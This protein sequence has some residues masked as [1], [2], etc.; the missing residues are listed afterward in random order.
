VPVRVAA[1][2][3]IKGLLSK[4]LELG[5]YHFISGIRILSG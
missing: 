5:V 2:T 3:F 1:A 4:K